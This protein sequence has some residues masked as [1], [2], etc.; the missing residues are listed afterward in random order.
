MRSIAAMLVKRAYHRT[1]EQAMNK[2]RRDF[3]RTGALAA[4]AMAL[5]GTGCWSTASAGPR[6][7]IVGAGIAGLTAA[8]RFKK[9]GMECPV[10]EATARAGGR[11]LTVENA[12]LDGAYVDFGA[13][14]IDSVHD[15]LLA[16]AKE[17]NVEL[18]NLKTDTLIPKVY[19]FEG[20]RLTEK[21]I[22][23]ALQPFVVRI[24]KDV[25]SVPE[26]LHYQNAE[27]FKELDEQSVSGYLK[28]IGMD[29]WLLR[30]F[31]TAMEGEYGMEA[32]AQSALNLLVMLSV[33]ITHDA[34]YHLLGN[35]HEVYKFKGGSQRFIDALEARVKDQLLTGRKL[36]ELNKEGNRYVLTFTGSGKTEVVKADYVVLTVPF[37]VLPDVKMNFSFPARKQ[38]CINEAGFG[39]AV[40]M[41]MGFT[42]RVWREQG[43]QGYTFSDQVDTP[44]WDSSQL[45]EADGGSLT[46]AGGGDSARQLASLSYAEIK[47]RW[48]AGADRVFPGAAAAYNGKI[49]KFAWPMHPFAKGSYTSYRAGQWSQF[50]GV[51]AEPFENILFAGEHCSIRHQGFMNGAAETG[52]KAAEEIIR[53]LQLTEKAASR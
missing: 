12:V 29:G 19:F 3:I 11:V 46:F 15:D 30:F 39:N 7:V 35:Y 41:A 17:L 53:K 23:D 22:V 50:A 31:E 49:S 8:Y 36:T 5:P 27:A 1:R 21:D 47:A 4:A 9:S 16:L 52:R 43:Y 6:V 38:Q 44:F 32:S 28:S 48:L 24:E 10:Y 34:H 33:P 25:A 14:F 51:E 40:K 26:N 45:V 37:K 13:E 20:K 42:R 2:G 18:L